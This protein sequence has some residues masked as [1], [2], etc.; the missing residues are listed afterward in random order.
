MGSAAAA[1]VEQ[2]IISGYA[3][4][5]FNPLANGSAFYGEGGMGI[6]HLPLGKFFVYAVEP[7]PVKAF[8]IV[9][10]EPDIIVTGLIVIGKGDFVKGNKAVAV[11]IEQWKN[12]IAL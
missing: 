3:S 6:L 11:P 2:K 4:E 9:V 12:A 8:V 1:V 5:G 7:N 10:P